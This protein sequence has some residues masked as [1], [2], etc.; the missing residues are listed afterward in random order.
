MYFSYSRRFE[1]LMVKCF[2]FVFGRF[3]M[4]HGMFA[5]QFPVK[6]MFLVIVEKYITKCSKMQNPSMIPMDGTCYHLHTTGLVS[7]SW[8]DTIL[9]N[10]KDLSRKCMVRLLSTIFLPFFPAFDVSTK[11]GANHIHCQFNDEFAFL[12][13]S[14]LLCSMCFSCDWKKKFLKWSLKYTIMPQWFSIFSQSVA[15]YNMV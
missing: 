15:K 1:I 4:L 12:A 5:F 11:S 9:W 6:I 13:L 14:K 3:W 2:F 7:N 10:L 8:K